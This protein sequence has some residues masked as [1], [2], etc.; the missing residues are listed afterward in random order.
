MRRAVCLLVLSCLAIAWTSSTGAEAPPS[1][2]TA[3]GSP[4][5]LSSPYGIT[6]DPRSGYV[7]VSDQNNYRICKFTLVGGFVLAWGSFGH[8]DGQFSLTIGL[9][10]DGSGNVYVADYGN[11]RVQEFTSQG[12]FVRKWG[13]QGSGNG[14]FNGP[15]AVCVTSNGD[16]VVTDSGNNRVER[17]TPQGGYLGQWSVVGGATTP[18]G[19]VEDAAGN[20]LI[21]EQGASS[22][23]TEYSA[24]GTFIAALAVAGTAP[25][26]LS[27]PA[28]LALDALGNIYVADYQNNRIQKFSA[29]GRWLSAWGPRVGSAPGLFDRP[30]D[31]A[32]DPSGSIYVVDLGNN[33][34]QVFAYQTVSALRTTWGALK[35]AY[36]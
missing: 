31:V 6:L 7:Y 9:A 23:L 22:R 21:A 16:I 12:A 33:R 20:F 18:H 15:R 35:A 14:E 3:F 10:I 27:G 28:G 13:Q 36:R 25:G 32:I 17:F 4:P 1:F 24:T 11:S 26:Y 8:G 34:I 5:G 19:I 2:V 30:V 29:T